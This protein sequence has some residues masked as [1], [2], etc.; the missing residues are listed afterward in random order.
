[1]AVAWEFA[2]TREDAEDMVQ[3][4][5]LRVLEALPSYDPGRPFAPWFFTIVRNVG[6]NAASRNASISFTSLPEELEVEEEPGRCEERIDLEALMSRMPALME[7]LAPMQR[8]CLELCDLE[9]F[10]AKEVGEMLDVAPATVRVHLHRARASL[11]V[12]LVPH[13]GARGDT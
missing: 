12:Q 9:G 3:D 7:S 5:F 11:R 13:S 10:S 8:R 6:R 2:Q 1:M 4:G